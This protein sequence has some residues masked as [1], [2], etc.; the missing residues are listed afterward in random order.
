MKASEIKKLVRQ[1]HDYHDTRIEMMN[2]QRA[3]GVAILET[4]MAFEKGARNAL[5]NLIIALEK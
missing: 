5:W 4:Q 1:M 3:H 2:E